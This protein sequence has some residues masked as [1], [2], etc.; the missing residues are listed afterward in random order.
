M[1]AWWSKTRFAAGVLAAVVL[2]AGLS[3]PAEAQAPATTNPNANPDKIVLPPKPAGQRFRTE[4]IK[5][6]FPGAGPE[7]LT[8][9]ATKPPAYEVRMGGELKGYIFSTLDVVNATG[10]AGKPFDLVGGMTL[11][12]KITGAALLEDHESILD[13]GVGRNTMETFVA[14]F[15]AAK[16]NDW[17]A[18]KPDQVKG[19]TT[20]ARMMKSGMQA[21]ARVVASDRLPLD[22]KST[23]LNSSHT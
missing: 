5:T 7:S 20:S 10:Y 13:R 4:T 22:R 8:L 18:V 2:V 16:L 1:A 15:A 11:D 21:A 6:L 23:R 12:G 14:G 19:A 9:T 17:R 3:G